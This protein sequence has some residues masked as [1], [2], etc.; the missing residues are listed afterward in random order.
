[1]LG[2]VQIL[3]SWPLLIP[4][5]EGDAS[6][7]IHKSSTSQRSYFWSEGWESGWVV[8]RIALVGEDWPSSHPEPLPVFVRIMPRQ[9]L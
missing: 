1:M 8:S 2:A 5:L 3:Q 9:G 7:E 4:F 6:G